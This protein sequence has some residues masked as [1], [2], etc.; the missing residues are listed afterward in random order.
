MEP[1]HTDQPDNFFLKRLAEIFPPEAQIYLVGGAVRDRLLGKPYHDL[2]LIIREHAI[3]AARKA[4]NLLGGAFYILDIE[5][6]Y[7]RIVLELSDGEIFYLD[8]AAYQGADLES[9][10]RSRDFT[11]NA[12]ALDIHQPTHLVDPCKGLQDLKDHC[13]RACSPDSFNRDAIRVLRA[14]RQAVALNFKIEPQTRNWLKAAVPKVSGISAERIRDE[15]FRGLEGSH[16]SRCWRLYDAVGLLPV[17][18]PELE[19]LKGVYQDPPHTLDVWNHSLAVLEGL[20]RILGI[21]ADN[22]WESNAGDLKLAQASLYLGKFRDRLIQHINNALTPLRSR[23]AMLYLS[24]LYHDVAKPQ[25]ETRDEAGIQHFY[26]HE[27]SGA[28]M[29]S[30][31]CEAME[32]SVP[33]TRYMETMVKHHMRVHHLARNPD[34]I[35]KKAIYRFFRDCG[36]IGID[37][38]LLS[39][40]D[41]LGTYG[42]TLPEDRWL[43]EIQ[44]CRILLDAYWEQHDTVVA[45]QRVING[46]DLMIKLQLQPG[47]MIGRLLEAIREAQ[48]VGDVKDQQ[49][50]IAYA[51][52]LIRRWKNDPTTSEPKL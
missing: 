11:V 13:L 35:S 4:A 51:E 48:A 34:V 39:L 1:I 44:V 10:L 28:E 6:D 18:F 47:P 7:G 45:P 21:L 36:G 8:F 42:V 24:A 15:I 12:M 41:T 49:E 27:E 30:N 50:A 38:C 31:R 29:A 46:D 23:K 16:P 52:K 32:L 33:E 37:V 14:I 26:R 19:A 25:H 43:N 2:D 22:R 40:A 9:D 5:R 17:L 20:E 3:Q